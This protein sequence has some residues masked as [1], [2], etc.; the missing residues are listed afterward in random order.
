M[1]L[2]A[3][4]SARAV[5]R[6]AGISHSTLLG[7]E[8]GD[9]DP[10]VEVVARVGSVLGCRVSMRLNPGTGPAIK[11]HI[12]TAMFRG[13]SPHIG[14]SWRRY[15]E[16]PVFR[17][18][19]GYVDLALEED[20][21]PQAVAIEAHSLIERAEQTLR[22]IH[23]KSDALEVR[24]SE[25]GRP[26]PVSRV[27]LL[28]SVPSTRQAVTLAHDL[29]APAFPARMSDVV[30]ALQDPSLPW[31]GAAVLWMSV[32]GGEARLLHR[33]PPGIRLGR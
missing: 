20:L 7:L 33:P 8:E 32:V 31:P 15:P 6:A 14:A 29:F 21:H 4:L 10:T 2:D 17:P 25:L 9:F 1:R 27:L 16:V 11:D 22:W 19:R 5:A 18:I 26:R 12:Q 3:G 24:L 28:R 13:L 30:A 23:A